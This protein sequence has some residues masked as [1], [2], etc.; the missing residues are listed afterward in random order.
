MADKLDSKIDWALAQI[1][2]RTAIEGCSDAEVA[3]F[4]Q[5]RALKLPR[6][7]LRF[8]GALGVNSGEFLQ[9]SDFLFEQLDRLQSGAQAL[10][11][12]DQ[13]PRLPERAFVFCSHQGY[14]F[15]FFDLGE[16]PDPTVHYYMGGDRRF[17]VVAPAFSDWLVQTVRDEFP[18]VGQ[19]PH[20]TS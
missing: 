16:G 2:S 7:Y 4:Q 6:A 18:D 11:D 3:T 1:R 19:P 17:K 8:L 15:L 5:E 14:Q 10:L 13:G 12:D 9:G 20:T